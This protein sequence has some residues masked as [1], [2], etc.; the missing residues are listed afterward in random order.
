MKLLYQIFLSIFCVICGNCKA[1]CAE[2]KQQNRQEEKSQQNIE[3]DFLAEVLPVPELQSLVRLYY[4][5]PLLYFAGVYTFRDVDSAE[6]EKIVASLK[7]RAFDAT[8]DPAAYFENEKTLQARRTYYGEAFK[9]HMPYYAG[10]VRIG[11]DGSIITYD[12]RSFLNTIA[13]I[14]DCHG[15]AQGSLERHT[16]AIS[17][18]EVGPDGTIVTVSDNNAFIWNSDRTIRSDISRY[19]GCSSSVSIG[20]NGSIIISILPDVHIVDAY[21]NDKGIIKDASCPMV[22]GVDEVIVISRRFHVSIYDNNGQLRFSIPVRQRQGGSKYY[23]QYLDRY[24]EWDEKGGRLWELSRARLQ[25]LSKL[26]FEELKLVQNLLTQTQALRLQDQQGPPLVLTPEQVAVFKLIPARIQKNIEQ[27]FNSPS[28]ALHNITEEQFYE[29]YVLRKSLEGSPADLEAAAKNNVALATLLQKDDIEYRFDRMDRE[30]K[31]RFQMDEMM[32][33]ARSVAESLM[34]R[35]RARGAVGELMK[36]EEQKK[37]VASSP[38][39]EK[40]IDGCCCIL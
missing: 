37:V 38:P 30:F 19:K 20:L 35:E 18:V 39:S 4:I 7:V 21:G 11:Q 27:F 1:A 14:W 15:S 33:E 32:E 31:E 22:V 24:F 17:K 2:L 12:P 28:F 34:K 29:A 40:K 3:K 6:A 10:N 9:V 23:S 16:D 8:K 26:S 13:R 36:N 5:E 25:E